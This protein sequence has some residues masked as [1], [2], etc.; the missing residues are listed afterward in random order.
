MTAELVQPSDAG[1]RQ[2]TPRSLWML[3]TTGPALR[4][5]MIGG[6][7]VA[8][9][10]IGSA[11]DLNP[12]QLAILLECLVFGGLLAIFLL[13][14][15][16]RAVG[17]RG[18][19]IVSACL[20]AALLLVAMV[21]GPTLQSGPAT[22]VILFL[23]ASLLGIF[24]AIPAPVSQSMLNDATTNDRKQRSALQS[25]WSAGQP[26]G[27]IAAAFIGGILV[28]AFGWWAALSIPLTVSIIL[29]LSLI[30]PATDHPA[31]EDMAESRPPA[32]EILIIIVALLAFEIWSTWG[33]LASW[34]DP[35]VL[36]MMLVTI[37]VSLVTI[38]H[39]R[40]TEHP[41]I[42]MKPF[43][44]TGFAAAFAILLIYQLP[45]T[46]EFEVLLLTELK[47]TSDIAIG[48]RTSFGNAAQVAGTAVAAALLLRRRAWLAVAAGFACSILG[49]A[50]YFLYFWWYGDLLITLTRAVAGFGAGLLLPVLFV[51]ALRQMPARLHF[52]AST[53]L[54]LA[55]IGGTELGLAVYDM[56][57][58]VTSQITQSRAE[59][60]VAVEIAQLLTILATG[61]LTLWTLRFAGLSLAVPARFDQREQPSEAAKSA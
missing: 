31:P 58:D 16:I 60:Y 30:H 23:S 59:G 55:T 26:I 11:F 52:A 9:E 46:A 56:V 1:E 51:V 29:A 38:G 45:T 21:F 40:R 17:C 39:V 22:T 43:A 32:S 20:A 42:S 10:A 34:L 4:T 12:G 57:L 8:E 24:V 53:W 2:G 33:S 54:V 47:N 35:A 44:V 14:P 13:P 36:A 41:A 50:S 37:V 27:F 61:I 7:L 18:L 5:S 6:V 49:L 19:S 3:V 15:L 25:V 48:N 28:E